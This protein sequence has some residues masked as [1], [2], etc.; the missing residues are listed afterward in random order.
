MSNRINIQVGYRVLA[1]QHDGPAF[2]GKLEA[3]VDIIVAVRGHRLR[4]LDSTL[5]EAIKVSATPHTT[6]H[7]CVHQFSAKSEM[8]LNNRFF[9]LQ[10]L[11]SLS[12]IPSSLFYL[13]SLCFPFK[14]ITK[15][16]EDQPLPLIVYNCDTRLE[17]E[18]ELLPTR[19]W[20]GEGEFLKTGQ[21]Y[22]I[23]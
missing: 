15:G 20:Q 12:F 8:N 16:S 5:I 7:I 22:S 6:L 13:P 1:V 19:K 9:L 2:R 4:V 18:I 11:P 10:N 23:F 14:S 3:T 21:C 17:R